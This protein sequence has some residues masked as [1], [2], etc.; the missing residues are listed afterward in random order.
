[1]K[2]PVRTKI[3]LGCAIFLIGFIVY[4]ATSARPLDWHARRLA[5]CIGRSDVGCVMGYIPESEKQQLNLTPDSLRWLLAEM[6]IKPNQ[7]H[8]VELTVEQDNCYPSITYQSTEHPEQVIGFIITEID[9]GVRVPGLTQY[10]LIAKMN[11]TG[12]ITDRS[13]QTRID[14]VRQNRQELERNGFTG[15]FSFSKPFVPWDEFIAQNEARIARIE[16][17]KRN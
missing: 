3:L 17:A 10:L 14:Y 13:F 9:E 2:L 11:P 1:M 16:A 8:S 6:A 5:D 4:R 7:P 15:I 12:T